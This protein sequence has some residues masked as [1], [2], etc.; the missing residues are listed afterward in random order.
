M[1]DILKWFLGI[2]FGLFLLWVFMGGPQRVEERGGV[3]PTISAPTGIGGPS[4][5]PGGAPQN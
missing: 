5:V 2:F 1:V 3:S 4:G